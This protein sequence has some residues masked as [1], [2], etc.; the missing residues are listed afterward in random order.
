MSPGSDRIQ[1]YLR[2]LERA[3]RRRGLADPDDL[4]EMEDHLYEAVAAGLRGGLSQA[5][6]VEQA[7]RRF[8]PAGRV[9]AAFDKE[10][11][12]AMQK[13]YLVLAVASG[14]FIAYLDARP[15]WDA[16][17]ILAGGLLLSAGLLTLLG[18]RRPWL[19][20]LAVGI[21][22]PLHDLYTTHDIS[23]LLVLLFP[24]AGAYLGWAVR[25][26]LRRVI[27]LA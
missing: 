10:R 22:L 26:G 8:G 17:G 1:M 14:L 15:G 3:L 5:E 2:S 23:M 13:I 16:T 7:L 18:A 9:A 11:S 12:S 19:V 4:A 21:W 27:H 6:A 20:A 25:W 24:L